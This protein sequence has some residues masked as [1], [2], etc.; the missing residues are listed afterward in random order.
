[1]LCLQLKPTVIRKKKSILLDSYGSPD[2][3]GA[4]QGQL[5]QLAK[6]RYERKADIQ[7]LF[8]EAIDSCHL[9]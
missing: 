4:R 7:Q 2:S 1:M 8:P 5:L 3:D 9:L 6:V